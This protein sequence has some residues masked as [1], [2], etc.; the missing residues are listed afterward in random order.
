MGDPHEA[1]DETAERGRLRREER[2]QHLLDR[3]DHTADP[4]DADRLRYR[5]AVLRDHPPP[6]PHAEDRDEGPEV[7]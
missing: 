1:R 4:V 6:R 2:A 7:P 3:A 5:A